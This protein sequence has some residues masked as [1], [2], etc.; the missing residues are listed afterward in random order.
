MATGLIFGA[1]PAMAGRF[2]PAPG[3]HS[4]GRATHASHSVRR[5]LIVAQVAVSFMLL[6]G[7]GLTI[8]TL[9]KLHQVDPGFRTEDVLST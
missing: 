7:A 9:F 5:V 1:V 2:S 8:R 4:A 3:L 6:V